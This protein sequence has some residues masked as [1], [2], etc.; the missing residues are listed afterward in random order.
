MKI[1]LLRHGM[2]RLL[3]TNQYTYLGIPF[4]ESLDLEPIIVKMNDKIN[5]TN[6]SFYRFLTGRNV[7][8]YFKI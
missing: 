2:N 4:N 3:S 1:L 8:F 5:Y 6:N 7:P